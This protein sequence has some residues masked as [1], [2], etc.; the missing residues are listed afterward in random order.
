MGQGSRFKK[1]LERLGKAIIMAAESETSEIIRRLFEWDPHAVS[2]D[3]KVL[4]SRDVTR[5]VRRMQIGSPSIDSK[6]QPITLS[7]FERKW[8]KLPRFQQTRGSQQQ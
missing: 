5:H 7:A 4:L 1:R 2:T 3:G 6:S 8:Q